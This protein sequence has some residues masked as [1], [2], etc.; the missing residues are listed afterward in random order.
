VAVAAEAEEPARD[1]LLRGATDEDYL[2][3]AAEDAEE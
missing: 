2:E 3:Q 1:T